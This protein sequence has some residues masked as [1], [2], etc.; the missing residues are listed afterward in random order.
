MNPN[1]LIHFGLCCALLVSAATPLHAAEAP[2]KPNIIL[3]MPDDVGYGDYRCLGNPIINTPSVDSFRK[4]SLLFTQFH[5]SPTCAPTRAALMGGCHEFKCG[6]TDTNFG[7]ERMSLETHTLAQMLKSAGYSTGIFGKWHLGDQAAYQ[8]DKRGFDEVFIHGSGGI[9]QNFGG[10]GGDVFK[11]SYHSPIIKHNG[12]FVKT[13]GYCTDVFFDQSIRWMEN[14]RGGGEPFFAYI[15]L[16]A[17]HGPLHVPEEYY[18]QYLGKEGVDEQIA[19]FYGMIENID[20]NFGKLLK[21]LDEWEIAD[22]T[23]VI[24]LGGDNGGHTAV[25]LFNAG[26]SGTKGT[27][28][29]G[30][31][32]VPMF[33]RWPG[34]TRAGEDCDSLTAHLDIFPTL[35]EIAGFQPSDEIKKQVEGRSL[36]PLLKNPKA[37][38][39]DRHLIT[40]VGRWKLGAPPA[41]LVAQ[42][43]VRN[44]R[45]TLFPGAK[46]GPK[47]YDLNE[48]PAQERDVAA[49]HPEI[50]RD[51]SA[52]YDRW[53]EEVQPF[54]VN[55]KAYLTEPVGSP[56]D[57]GY[58]EQFGLSPS[59]TLTPKT[60]PG[61]KARQTK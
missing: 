26:M 60:L 6:V 57:I 58:R 16:N 11:N 22:D 61:G 21:K 32:R 31:T 30:G 48:D 20:S 39:A 40:H 24:Y 9:G 5:V 29:E 18:Q 55:E 7:R 17:A 13:D 27:A 19:K 2:A 4:E 47:L 36:L 54:L 59:R 49:E 50:V 43:S 38:W 8:P 1:R 52:S 12:K 33:I 23:I 34:V 45:Y 46:G 41:K 37:E 28:Y 10:C 15:S 25:P 14:R 42:C 51:L 44:S 53:W 35:A 56:F 3:I